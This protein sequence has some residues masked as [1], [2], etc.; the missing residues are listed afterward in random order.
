LIIFE[1][2]KERTIEKVYKDH[3]IDEFH[4]MCKL[5]NKHSRDD[6]KENKI[7]QNFET[8]VEELKK[9]NVYLNQ[10]TENG[11]MPEK[12][13]IRDLEFGYNY[14]HSVKNPQKHQIKNNIKDIEQR[15]INGKLLL[16]E[17][18]DK[19]KEYLKRPYELENYI[20]LQMFGKSIIKMNNEN[21]LHYI[22]FIEKDLEIQWNREDGNISE[23]MSS[24]DRFEILNNFFKGY[25]NQITETISKKINNE[26]E[27]L[28][29]LK[30][31]NLSLNDAYNFTINKFKTL[32][33]DITADQ[34][35]F[36]S[37]N[38]KWTQIES[39]FIF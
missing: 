29:F 23:K 8:L 32:K 35:L 31:I 17:W 34:L 15:I 6:L 27:G 14:D 38:T 4:S 3:K 33:Q 9:F 28:K 20:S 18:E 36:C 21:F 24:S 13:F 16:T 7:Y 2:E 19:K 30:F 12:K 39:K 1:K 11:I 10:F 37:K 22:K 25:E 26:H 5:K